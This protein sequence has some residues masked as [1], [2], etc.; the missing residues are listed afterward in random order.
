MELKSLLTKITKEILLDK[1][2]TSSENT[3]EGE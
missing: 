3:D 2:E 1:L